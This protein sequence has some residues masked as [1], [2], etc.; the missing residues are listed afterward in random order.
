MKNI[1]F[2]A[3][4]LLGTQVSFG[5]IQKNVGDYT[6]LKVYDKIP[7]ELIKSNSNRVEINGEAEN[8]VEVINKNG[9]LKIRMSTLN[10]LK[11]DKVKVKVYYNKSINDIQAS[12]GSLINSQ[13]KLKTTSLKLTSNEGS[14]IKIDVDTD[15]LNVKINSG[16]EAIVNGKTSVLDVIANSGGKFFGKTLKAK[17]A[18]LTTNAG[19]EIEAN[20]SEV[21]DSKT[22][23]GGNINIYGSPKV[24][25]DKKFAGGNIRYIN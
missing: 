8:D 1:F 23:A 6:S 15:K 21:V 17:T 18:N 13:D 10:A 24:K 11:G 12:Q 25:S 2:T 20:V 22:R 16:G 3:V 4:M 14:S 5:Q 19:G 9:D 7:V